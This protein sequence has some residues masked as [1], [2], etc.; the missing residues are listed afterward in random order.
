MIFRASPAAIVCA[1]IAFLTCASLGTPTARA[2]TDEGPEPSSSAATAPK[3]H[4]ID[5]PTTIDLGH[6]LTLEL[7]ASDR[8]LGP[9]DSEKALR[10]MGNLHNEGI[11]G[12][13]APKGEKSEWFAVI[14]WNGAGHVNDDEKIDPDKL[15]ESMR[16][17]Q[18]EANEERKS[19]GFKELALDGWQVS[20]SYDKD[21][22]HLSWA[23]I[24][25]DTE[26][27]SVNFNTRILGRESYASINLVTDPTKLDGF[28][29]EG[30]TLLQATTFAK[31]QRYEDFN[32]KTDKL[33]EYGLVGLITGGVGL[34]VAKLVKIGLLANIILPYHILLDKAREE[35]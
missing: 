35:K 34:G 30:V 13:V 2:A 28:R 17:A 26:G 14:D 22:H 27:K 7:P 9:A 4:F 15:L 12:I 24:V 23:L 29:G 21:K 6:A 18:K 31:G 10:A 20:P 25:S 19:Q 1:M 11:L 3:L 5:G 8:Y 32:K 16:D 33:A